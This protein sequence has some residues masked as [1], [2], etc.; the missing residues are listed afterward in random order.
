MSNSVGCKL[1]LE[2]REMLHH[3][4]GEVSIFSQ[5]EQVLLVKCIDVVFGI[6]VDDD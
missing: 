1:H 6:L 2:S 3:Q 4:R 5:R